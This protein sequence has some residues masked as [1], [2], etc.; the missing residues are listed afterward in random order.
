MG[1]IADV[2]KALLPPSLPAEQIGNII[3]TTM[4]F[5]GIRAA[6]INTGS[7]TVL[8]TIFGATHTPAK[9]CLYLPAIGITP[10]P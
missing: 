6:P 2:L 1:S 4:P 3:T 7:G 5:G 8:A 9:T 10:V